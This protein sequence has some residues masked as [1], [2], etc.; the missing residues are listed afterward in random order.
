[1]M[2]DHKRGPP[3]SL[4]VITGNNSEMD[5]LGH[6]VA[7]KSE[8]LLL[9]FIGPISVSNPLRCGKTQVDVHLYEFCCISYTACFYFIHSLTQQIF[10]IHICNIQICML[11][12]YT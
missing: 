4:P 7:E 9:L 1:M 6:Q 12:L 5:I 10:I 8:I 11:Y 2:K 3:E